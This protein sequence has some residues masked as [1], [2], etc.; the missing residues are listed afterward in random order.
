MET[1]ILKVTPVIASN[2]LQKSNTKNRPLNQDRVDY[3]ADQMKKGLW[4]LI[5]QGISFDEN[6]NII[7][8]QHRLAAI[9]K[10]NT[11]QEFLIVF[12]VPYEYFTVYDDMKVRGLTDVFNIEFDTKN[13]VVKSVIVSKYLMFSKNQKF[14]GLSSINTKTTKTEVLNEYKNNAAFYDLI[15]DLALKCYS[16]LR[17]YSATEIGYISAYLIKDLKYSLDTVKAFFKQLHNI[18]PDEST[19]TKLLREKIITTSMGR[20]SIN[21]NHKIQLLA[22]CW[23]YWINGIELKLLRV[24][25]GENPI[26]E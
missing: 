8:G 23:N 17:L 15:S 24:N 1:K 21:K 11:S 9:V 3:Y 4:K 16:K 13:Y 6:M 22:K 20:R 7:D 10:S 14:I 25:E 5:G 2:W 18:E 12:G 19:V 26:F